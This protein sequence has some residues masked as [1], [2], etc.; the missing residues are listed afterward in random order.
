MTSPMSQLWINIQQQN[1]FGDPWMPLEEDFKERFCVGRKSGCRRMDTACDW[2]KKMP[3]LSRTSV[4]LR[5]SVELP[6]SRI[7]SPVSIQTDSSDPGVIFYAITPPC[8]WFFIEPFL[9][10]SGEDIHLYKLK[11]MSR[12]CCHSYR[13]SLL[14]SPCHVGLW[15]EGK[16][17]EKHGKSLNWGVHGSAWT[18]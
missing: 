4:E 17:K 14:S 5:I 2:P 15:P 10:V 12:G 7:R 8:W 3:P 13:L 16:V 6:V 11:Y 9:R 18:F 1:E